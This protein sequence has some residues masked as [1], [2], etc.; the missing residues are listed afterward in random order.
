MICRV[1]GREI[2]WKGGRGR[3]PD[4]CLPTDAQRES[5]HRSACHQWQLGVEQLQAAARYLPPMSPE[6]AK[7]QRSTLWGILN[8]ALN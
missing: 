4:Y 8:M 1:C 5:G 3:P 2:A 7:I 6:Y